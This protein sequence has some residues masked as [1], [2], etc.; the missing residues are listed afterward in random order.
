MDKSK[1]GQIVKSLRQEQINYETGRCWTQ[2]ELADAS[3][4]SKRSI[5]NIEQGRRDTLTT[6]ELR[7]LADALRLSTLERHEFFA[8]AT[9]VEMSSIPENENRPMPDST[10]PYLTPIWNH[11]S[12]LQLPGYL[13]DSLTRV[14]GINE[15]MISFH[16]MTHEMLEAARQT[17]VG[18]TMLG[19]FFRQTSPLRVAL[20]HRWHEMAK[21]KIHEFQYTA[22]RDRWHNGFDK[23]VA[24]LRRYPRAV[25]F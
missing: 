10:Q 20:G 24:A 3:L 7:H 14:V 21:T 22:L 1:F 19:L 2:K 25:Q 11:F 13:T 18:C 16:G 5:E 23:I 15:S 12:T 6:N 17:E 4:L 8:A 9:D